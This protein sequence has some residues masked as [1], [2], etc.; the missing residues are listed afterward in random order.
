MA[1]GLSSLRADRRFTP[2]K[3]Y[4]SA[5]GTHFCWKLSKPQALVRPEELG[6]SIKIIHLIGSRSRDLGACSI[7][8][9]PLG[10]RVPLQMRMKYNVI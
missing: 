2:Q 5:S 6:K 1:V 7:V 9:L 10:Y 3:H 8:S 4:V